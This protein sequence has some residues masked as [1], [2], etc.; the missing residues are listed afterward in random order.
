ME[1]YGGLGQMACGGRC[2]SMAMVGGG[3][4]LDDGEHGQWMEEYGSMDWLCWRGCFF[5]VFFLFG[6]WGRGK[7]KFSVLALEC[8]GAVVGWW[9]MARAASIDALILNGSGAVDG[10]VM[11]LLDDGSMA[12]TGPKME[13]MDGME[14]ME[15]NGT[16]CPVV[17]GG[18]AGVV[19]EALDGSG[20]GSTDD[21]SN[22]GDLRVD[23]FFGVKIK[24]KADFGIRPEVEKSKTKNAE[25]SCWSAF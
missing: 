21:G 23:R 11:Q 9:W 22:A 1:E 17:D 20:G 5:F 13:N 7:F 8:S 18:I 24:M 10:G 12:S 16:V 6:G 3:A 4:C 14:N 2:S 15:W 25:G 19:L